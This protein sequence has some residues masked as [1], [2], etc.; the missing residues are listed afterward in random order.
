M[1]NDHYSL[2]TRQTQLL[3]SL[4][5]SSHIRSVI[6]MLLCGTWEGN[7][8]E[9]SGHRRPLICVTIPA[10]PAALDSAISRRV[11]GSRRVH[12]YLWCAYRGNGG[13]FM[14]W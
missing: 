5:L 7:Q 13:R 3:I 2:Q 8:P 14:Q 1:Q 12:R 6:H 9:N 4:S 11:A 10:L